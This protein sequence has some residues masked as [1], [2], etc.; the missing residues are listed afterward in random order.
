M[1]AQI[2]FDIQRD[3]ENIQKLRENDPEALNYN[4]DPSQEM[5]ISYYILNLFV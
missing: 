2:L 3:D 4:N 5:L 1:Q